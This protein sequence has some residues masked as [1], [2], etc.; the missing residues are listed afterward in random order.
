MNAHKELS[1]YFYKD[2]LDIITEYMEDD[3]TFYKVNI[4]ICNLSYKL[5]ENLFFNLLF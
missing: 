5:Y 4:L 2:I 3:W 1:K